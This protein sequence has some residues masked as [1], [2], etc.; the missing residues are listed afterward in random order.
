[1][2]LMEMPYEVRQETQKCQMCY[3]WTFRLISRAIEGPA[4]YVESSHIYQM[5]CRIKNGVLRSFLVTG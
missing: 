3:I 2:S 1:M 4:G 5:L